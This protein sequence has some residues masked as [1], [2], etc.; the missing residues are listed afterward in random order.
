MVLS[1]LVC[2]AG[3]AGLASPWLIFLVVLATQALLGVRD[4]H[5]LAFLVV[6]RDLGVPE[7]QLGLVDQE[8]LVLLLLESL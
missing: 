1:P 5:S 8:C 2:L 7:D 6:L 4:F 3:L